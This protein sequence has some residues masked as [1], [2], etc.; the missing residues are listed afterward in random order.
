[1]PDQSTDQGSQPLLRGSTLLITNLTKLGGL[2]IAIH[3]TLLRA[4]ARDSVMALAA[5]LVLGAQVCENVLL[6]VIERFFGTRE[7]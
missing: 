3:E 4:N 6:R 5:L 2:A 7:D 1:M